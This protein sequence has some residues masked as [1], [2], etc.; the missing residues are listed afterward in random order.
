MRT[1]DGGAEMTTP[2]GEPLRTLTTGGHQS[3]LTGDLSTLLAVEDCYFRM[4]TTAEIQA[5]MTFDPDYRF[6]VTSKRDVVRMLGNAVTPC[7]ARD[8]GA[9]LIE[10]LGY[11]ITLAA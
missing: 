6:T 5:A 10:S 4:L 3:V 11:D 1:N 2:A 7:A 9:A 8:L